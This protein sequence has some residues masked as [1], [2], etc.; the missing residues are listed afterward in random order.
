MSAHRRRPVKERPGDEKGTRPR[1]PPQPPEAAARVAEGMDHVGRRLEHLY[2]VSKLLADFEDLD[3]TV[4]AALALTS[5][6]LPLRSAI[7]IKATTETLKMV[8]WRAEGHSDESMAAAK[9]NAQTAYAYLVGASP[10]EMFEL[11]ERSGGAALPRQATAQLAPLDRSRFLVIPLVV[12]RQPVFGALQLESATSLHRAD[13][14]FVN[15]IANQLAIALD[16]HRAWQRDIALRQQAEA[17]TRMR[18][19]IL[20][21]V[22]HDLRGPLATIMMATGLLARAEVPDERRRNP[23]KAFAMIQ[24]A[25]ER[26]LRLIEDLLDFASIQVGQLGITRMPREPATLVKEAIA[27]FEQLAREKHLHLE[28]EVE[29]DLSTLSCDRDRIIQVFSN[30]MSNAF[31]VTTSGG[32]IILRARAHEREVLFVVSDT[33]PGIAEED[34][35]HLFE[36]HWR[37]R[38]PGYKGT[39]LGLH[40]AKGIVEAHGG[41]IWAESTLGQGATFFFTIPAM[42]GDHPAP[43]AGRG[44]P[45]RA[46]GDGEPASAGGV[47]GRA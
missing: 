5:G 19:Q 10:A 11:T 36:R 17:A 40:I 41:R 35:Q 12:G 28:S 7:L 45:A 4:S 3:Q 43:G 46:V 22:S 26:M 9:A 44:S 27:N 30:L 29:A 31:K 23:P 42:D 16:R 47:M 34:L 25:A 39:G 32:S 8:T 38:E 20:A 14:V 18:E 1:T 15:A 13:L 37:S 24:R 2:E 33:G 21:V 6:T